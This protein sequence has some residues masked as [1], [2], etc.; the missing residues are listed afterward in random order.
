MDGQREREI[1]L[2]VSESRD[3]LNFSANIYLS[4]PLALHI[5]KRRRRKAIQGK[6]RPL[7][8]MGGLRFIRSR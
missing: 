6:T 1:S 4:I 5:H 3:V 7:K 8:A 2:T